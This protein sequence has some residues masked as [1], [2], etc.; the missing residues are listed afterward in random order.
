MRFSTDDDTFA[1]TITPM[2][3]DYGADFFKFQ[4]VTAGEVVGDAEPSTL[5]SAM[6]F[7][8]T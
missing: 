7:W 8:R 5:G 6:D 3:G 1:L 2:R 4:L